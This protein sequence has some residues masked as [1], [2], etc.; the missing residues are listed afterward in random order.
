AGHLD[1]RAD[2]D[3]GRLHVDEEEAEPAMPR[4]L[5]VGARDEDAPVGEA[6]VAGPDLLSRHEEDVAAE[7]GAGAAGGEVRAG[8]RLGE[9]L[10]PDLLAG[11]DPRQEAA[12]LRLRAVM[13]ERRPDQRRPDTDVDHRRRADAG[14]LLGEEELLDRRRA[15]PAVL[16][17]PVE[18]RP[19]ALEEAALPPAREADLLAGILG[20]RVLRRSPP[21][22]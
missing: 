3:A 4:R 12:L 8:V 21:R 5:E 7:L 18:P 13:D 15:A 14:V 17:R 1:E 22:G 6:G 9:A 16:A 11:Q 19:A 10:A 2:G 20:L